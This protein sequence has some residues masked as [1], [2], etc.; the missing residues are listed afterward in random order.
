[1]IP[2][3]QPTLPELQSVSQPCGVHDRHRL[4]EIAARIDQGEQDQGVIGHD[5]AIARIF[6]V[7]VVILDL[8]P[9]FA[10]VG[11]SALQALTSLTSEAI[12]EFAGI[13]DR[14]TSMR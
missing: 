10:P 9:R 14:P 13:T 2:I 6:V 7:A 4:V 3:R 8:L 1:M 5:M 12:S 11:S